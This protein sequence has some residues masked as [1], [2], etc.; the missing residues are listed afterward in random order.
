MNSCHNLELCCHNFRSK[1]FG[2]VFKT[3]ES[4]L[5]DM[6][7]SWAAEKEINKSD[8]TEV[9][10]KFKSLLCETVAVKNIWGSFF[11]LFCFFGGG[12]W[13]CFV[14]FFYRKSLYIGKFLSK[15]SPNFFFSMLQLQWRWNH[16]ILAPQLWSHKSLI[17]MLLYLNTCFKAPGIN[18]KGK[19]NNKERFLAP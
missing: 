3:L 16:Q 18:T 6:K 19:N 9:I 15:F 4:Y 7:G 14:L 1:I 13:F 2:K 12:I 10:L 11:I 5:Y 8:T 17:S